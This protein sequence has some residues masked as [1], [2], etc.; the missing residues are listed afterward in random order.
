MT[1]SEPSVRSI[2]DTADLHLDDG[3]RSRGGLATETVVHHL[4][5]MIFSGGFE[6]GDSLP[7]E[8]EIAARLGVSRLTVREG[9]R[10]LQTRGLIVV[11]HGRRPVI[12]PPNSAP[13]HDYFSASVL[14]DPRGLFELVEVRLAIEV[15]AAQLAAQHATRADLSS[16]GMALESMRRSVANK[17]D[18]NEA[19][20]QFHL[21]VASASGNRILSFLVEGME[22]PLRQSRLQSI[23]GHHS[24]SLGVESLVEQ[25][26]EI[27]DKIVSRDA[28]GA[29]ASMR[30][31]LNQTRNDLRAAFASQSENVP[32][33]EPSHSR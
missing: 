20:L 15:Y 7:S 12:A 3:A 18:L 33:N 9:V 17:N 2:A 26:Q 21:A 28:R 1:G 16:L 8:S 27:F 24:R 14:R 22:E 5:Q 6:P 4:E 23:R 25:H 11:S 31:H 30:K 19:D 13:L 10:A 29:A 32:D